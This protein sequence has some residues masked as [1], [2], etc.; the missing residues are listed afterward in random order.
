MNSHYAYREIDIKSPLSK[1]INCLWEYKNDHGPS[2]H[3]ILPDGYFD[4]IFE[5]NTFGISKS[6]LTGVWTIPQDVHLI[7]GT[8]L[9]GVQFR[10]IASEYIFNTSIKSILNSRLEFSPKSFGIPLNHPPDMESMA[11]AIQH[12]ANKRLN[13]VEHMDTRKLNLSSML[14]SRQ[15]YVGVEELASSVFWSSRQINRHFNKQYGFSLKSFTDILKCYA[16]YPRLAKGLLS[17]EAYYFDQSHYINLTSNKFL[18]LNLSFGVYLFQFQGLIKI[19][20]L[21]HKRYINQYIP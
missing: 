16:S 19:T 6:Y 12:W 4:M 5:F 9:M 7:Q 3:T 1:F 11:D 2:T 20:R 21:M 8:H 14:Y 15:G 18:N 17:P 13:E 10:L